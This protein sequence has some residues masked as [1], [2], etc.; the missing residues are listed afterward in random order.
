MSLPTERQIRDLFTTLRTYAAPSGKPPTSRLDDLEQRLVTAMRRD[1]TGTN[2]I[3]GY[4]ASTTSDGRGGNEL[5]SVEAGANRTV[6]GKPE[7]DKIHDHAFHAVTF[8]VEAAGNLGAL[9]GRLDA[10]DKLSA[11]DRKSETTGPGYCQA[12]ATFCTGAGDDRLRSGYC[13]ACR[14]AWDRGGR[15]PRAEFERSRRVP[16]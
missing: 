16:T 10:I 4:S 5:T 9:E 15:K 8:L 3:D 2:T 13:D 7:L 1:A 14:K 11:P 6:F 12:C